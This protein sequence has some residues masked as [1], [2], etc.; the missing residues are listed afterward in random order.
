MAETAPT[1]GSHHGANGGMAKASNTAVT[2]AV[3]SI[4]AG[5]TGRPRSL[6]MMASEPQAAAVANSR[7]THIPQPKYQT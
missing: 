3:P 7:V 5:L 2:A 1:T 6:S 4:R